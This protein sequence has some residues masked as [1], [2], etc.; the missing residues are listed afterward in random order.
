LHFQFETLD[1]EQYQEVGTV[2]YPNDHEITRI[3]EQKYLTGQTS[4]KTTLVMEYPQAYKPNQNDPYYPILNEENRD[5]LQLYLKE[6][7]KLNGTVLFAG[8]LA[9]YKYYDM[10]QAVV[11][12]LGLFEKEIANSTEQRKCKKN[13]LI[14]V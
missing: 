5:R 13:Q 11:R 9:D 3:T 14:T 8:R 7:E 1:T 2:N 4:P 10:D 6:V 12:A